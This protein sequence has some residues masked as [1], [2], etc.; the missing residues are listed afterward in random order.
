ML[1]EI[2]RLN[3]RGVDFEQTYAPDD[4]SLEDEYAR[5]ATNARVVGR[6]SRQRDAISVEGTIDTAVETV[7]DRCLAPVTLP[8]NVAFKAELGLADAAGEAA[9]LQ[10]ADM[11]FSTYEGDAIRLDEIA[12][13]QILLALPTRQLCA[14]DCKG[15]CPTCGANRNAETCGC[16]QRETDPRWSALAEMKRSES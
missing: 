12:R 2:E 7:C 8:V 10:D 3:E 9:E 4:L 11:D 15:L 14:A 6:A 16:E 13:E 5:L 1:I